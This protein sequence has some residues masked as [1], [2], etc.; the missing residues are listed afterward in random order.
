MDLEKPVL[1]YDGECGLC[2]AVVR[3]ML[4]RDRRGVLRFAPLQGATAQA[5]LRS[6][7]M[8]TEDFDSIVFIQDLSRADTAYFLRTAGAFRAMAELGGG[9]RRLARIMMCV[10]AGCSDLFYKC[11]ARLRYRLFGQYQP[12]PLPNPEWARRFL[13]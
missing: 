9:W 6:H 12:S 13:D 2:N 5:F 11:V 8:N 10:P 7:G 4:A 3:F 1:L